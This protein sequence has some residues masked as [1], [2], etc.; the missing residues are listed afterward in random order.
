[1]KKLE[2][3]FLPAHLYLIATL[4]DVCVGWFASAFESAFFVGASSATHA[5]II[6]VAIGAFGD[7]QPEGWLLLA[8]FWQFVMPAAVIVSY[9]ISVF[10]K[11]YIPMLI[12]AALDALFSLAATILGPLDL[13]SAVLWIGLAVH[14]LYY[15]WM[16]YAARE[17]KR[18]RS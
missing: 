10:R 4:F 5:H 18:C 8:F 11:N 16:L 6:F 12:V 9:L 13:Q 1:M 3:S 14:I 15:L 17:M 2:F 7:G